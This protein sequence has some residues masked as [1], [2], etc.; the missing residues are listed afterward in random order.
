MV[1][2]P[3]VPGACSRSALRHSPF[4]PPS[5]FPQT[6]ERLNVAHSR[7]TPRRA[8]RMSVNRRQ[9]PFGYHGGYGITSSTATRTCATVDCTYTP[10]L[11]LAGA[12]GY[13]HPLLCAPS[14]HPFF[15]SSWTVITSTF[16][17][18]QP[19]HALLNGL[20]F[21]FLA[22]TA[23][24]VLGNTQFLMLYLGSTSCPSFLPPFLNR[25]PLVPVSIENFQAVHS[26]ALAR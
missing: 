20:T 22:P 6:F 3:D 11:A 9:A 19:G 13:I 21:W 18:A 10:L 17:H 15:F 26:R 4:A 14:S 8:V 2:R 24:A 1:L 7:P 16:S 12:D 25:R 23:L 5:P